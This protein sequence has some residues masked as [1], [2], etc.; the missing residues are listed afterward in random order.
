[1]VFV[2]AKAASASKVP[3]RGT[4][5]CVIMTYAPRNVWKSR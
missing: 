4:R 1:M 3:S 2:A 5:I